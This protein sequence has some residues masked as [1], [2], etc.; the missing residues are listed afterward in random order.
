MLA[1]D[2]LPVKTVSVLFNSNTRLLELVD[3]PE[4]GTDLV[5]LLR[6]NVF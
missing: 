5:T 2:G 1:R 6:S 3:L 4:S